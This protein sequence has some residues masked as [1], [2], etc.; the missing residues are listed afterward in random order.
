MNKVVIF[1]LFAFSA[2]N[3]LS[4]PIIIK[5]EIINND[6]VVWTEDDGRISKTS[7]YIRVYISS[8]K[9]KL[10]TIIG[11]EAALAYVV[12]KTPFKPYTLFYHIVSLLTL[13]K[14]RVL[15]ESEDDLPMV[16]NFTLDTR[17][18]V[19]NINFF[20]SSNIA[21]HFSSS[22]ISRVNNDIKSKFEF[23]NDPNYTLYN[24]VSYTCAVKRKDIISIF[25]Q[26]I[27]YYTKENTS[28]EHEQSR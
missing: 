23:N 14:I 3:A 13:E 25:E 10:P 9:V 8:D 22:E 19:T 20:I 27:K 17:G 5:K 15:L 11:P 16:V 1:L 26:L 4:Q 12:G 7:K 18:K 6:T 2:I 21:S 28:N 24:Y